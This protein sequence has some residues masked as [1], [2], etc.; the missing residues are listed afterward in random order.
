MSITS[1]LLQPLLSLV[2]W[3]VCSFNIQLTR[4]MGEQYRRPFIFCLL[5]NVVCLLMVFFCSWHSPSFLPDPL[6]D[7]FLACL[8]LSFMLTLLS[9]PCDLL[10]FFI[11][12]SDVPI[13]HTH[14]HT[15]TVAS[16]K[17]LMPWTTL[18]LWYGRVCFGLL[19]DP[20]IHWPVLSL[21]LYLFLCLFLLIPLSFLSFFLCPQLE[22]LFILCLCLHN[23]CASIPE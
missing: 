15:R 17:S 21:S 5:L 12:E 2:Q 8:S 14:T 11:Q 16:K 10:C 13:K 9:L 20:F 19:F 4:G 23:N 1:L 18:A 3:Q 6:S 7:R 22:S